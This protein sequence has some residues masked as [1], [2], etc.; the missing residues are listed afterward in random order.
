LI[1]KGLVH[2]HQ[3]EDSPDCYWITLLW[4]IDNDSPSNLPTYLNDWT[5]RL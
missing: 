3:D 5:H 1:Q 2:S 4:F